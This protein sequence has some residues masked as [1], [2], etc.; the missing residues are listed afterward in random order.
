MKAWIPNKI[1]AIEIPYSTK[2]LFKFNL[3]NKNRTGRIKMN[4]ELISNSLK[5]ILLKQIEK[6][7]YRKKTE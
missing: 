7:V 1:A 6:A 3:A 5:S 4:L 2:A